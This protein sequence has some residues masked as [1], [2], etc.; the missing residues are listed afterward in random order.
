MAAVKALAEKVSGVL[1]FKVLIGTQDFQKQEGNDLYRP[2][3]YCV[4]C[5]DIWHVNS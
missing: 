5:P 1:S 3:A 4:D 2:M